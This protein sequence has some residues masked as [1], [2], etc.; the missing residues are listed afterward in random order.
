MSLSRAHVVCGKLDAAG[1]DVWRRHCTVVAGQYRE[2]RGAAVAVAACDLRW[3]LTQRDKG[4]K[5]IAI[6]TIIG[7]GEGGP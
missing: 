6:E 5:K 7:D 1:G 4:E 2:R 3:W